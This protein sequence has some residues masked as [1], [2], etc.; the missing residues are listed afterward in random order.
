MTDKEYADVWEYQ[1]DAPMGVQDVADLWHWSTNYE[2]GKGPFTLFLD[3][4]GYSEDEYGETFYTVKPS[5]GLGY[6]E[7]DKLARALMQY[8]LNPRST[9]D[10][11]DGLMAFDGS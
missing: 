10:W 7:L 4:I 9:R 2:P 8:A 11:I 1:E 6:V 5:E 3:L